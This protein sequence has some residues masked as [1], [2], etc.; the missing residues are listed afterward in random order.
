MSDVLNFLFIKTVDEAS[1]V[2]LEE[3]RDL[4]PGEKKTRAEAS[5]RVSSAPSQS[6]SSKTRAIKHNML[7]F[8]G[9]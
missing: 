8:N 3:V 2:Q 6:P 9:I 1:V 5:T 7:L 4:I